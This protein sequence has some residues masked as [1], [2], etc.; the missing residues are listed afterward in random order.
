[1][2]VLK[3][4]KQKQ[5]SRILYIS[6]IGSLFASQLS[7][8]APP[9]VPYFT[10]QG[11]ALDS[12]GTA[13]LSDIVDFTFQI[14]DPAGLCLLYQESQTNIDLTT[15]SGQFSLL[16]GS[17]VG[18]SKRTSDPGLSMVNVFANLSTATLPPA[19]AN[20]VG[21]YTPAAGDGRILHVILSPHT[22]VPTALSPDLSINSVPYTFVAATLQG[23]L[24]TDFIN[25]TGTVSQAAVTTLTNASDAS[26]LHHHDS[27]YIKV[28]TANSSYSLGS[29]STL[30]LG[31]N[32][33]L[34]LGTF[35][36]DPSASLVA[37]DSGK[38][39]YNSGD[40]Q[41]YF[42]NGTSAQTLGLPTVATN[43][44]LQSD[45]SGKMSASS[46]TSTELGYLSGTTSSVQTQLSAKEPAITAG[47][48]NQ[49][50]RGDKSWQSFSSDIRASVSASS[51]LT[52]SVITGIIGIDTANTS[53]NGALTSA[54][55]NTFST[56]ATTTSSATNLNTASTIVKRDGSG[57]FAAGTITATL[58]GTSTNATNAT[59]V[60]TTATNTTNAPFF[61]TFVSS[62]SSG[63][64]GVN[65]AT[66]LTF[67]PSTNTL[68]TTTFS[69]A[70]SGNATTATNSSGFTGS[71]AGDVTGTQGTTAVATV[72]GVS[73]A[74]VAAG[75]TLANAATN[76][77]TASTI[78]KR[79]ASGNFT[80]GTI[81]ATLTGTSTNAT[82][83][84]TT[85]TNTTNATFYPS[86]VSSSS[87]GNQGVNTATG[88]TFNPSTN[89]LTTTTFSGALSGNATT[90][91]NAGGFTGSL[92]GD[93]TGT[94]GAT[95][96]STTGVSAGTY[97]SV[98]V[99]T[100][101]RVT[102]GTNP[103]T[104]A[105]YG[106]TNAAT[107]ASPTFTG[108]VTMPGTGIWNSSGNVG[109][110]TASPSTDLHIYGGNQPLYLR[111][112][113]FATDWRLGPDGSNSFTVYN[114]S[115]VGVYIVNGQTSWTANS[116][117]RL[118]KDF[119]PL[120]NALEGLLQITGWTYHYKTDSSTDPRRVGVI[121]QDVQ[122][123]LPE[124]IAEKD[125]Y[126]GVRYTELVPLI[127]NAVK[128]LY[129][130][131]MADSQEVHRALAS[132]AEST[133]V[134][135]LKAENAAI[136]QENAAIKSENV[137]I[138]TYLC[139]KDPQAPFC[140]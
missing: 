45:G 53:T 100:K 112:T 111:N 76:A 81:T 102:A 115:N 3:K 55:W 34:K 98:T 88:L 35:A 97:K 48:T 22:G 1:M 87:S 73:A 18:D 99:D 116:D 134:I 69:G 56:A 50:W 129:A 93:V 107:S 37:G 10:Y 60:A 120:D 126:L 138:K 74:N 8:A 66:G 19:T 86:F 17:D 65:T 51:P 89:T 36:S 75:A 5:L 72:G 114:S 127:I 132:K 104:L 42:W 91:T 135:Q 7:F 109:I 108:S 113:S 21:G 106:I 6:S 124:A 77:N 139:A 82:N 140:N 24:P 40:N 29:G 96:L 64:Q 67:N 11:R 79:D 94:Q 16:V 41:V 2:K 12:T 57:D 133:D 14:F 15:T 61:P 136:K 25:V 117:I 125:G 103:T 71:L 9:V 13:P 84:A 118:K 58:S 121:A 101:G 128:E 33:Y 119:Q 80:A 43:K 32:S 46:V 90:A 52:Y 30:T 27:Q 4:Q 49:Y 85:A 78:V 95:A 83:V 130:K 54:D 68:T 123:V 62:S 23:L 122:N 70:L 26:T 110:G 105:G 47:T 63:N 137:Q 31:S 20:C 44:A 92:S 28:G 59:N 38:V 39:W 131:W